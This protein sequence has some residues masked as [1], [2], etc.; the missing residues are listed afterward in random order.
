MSGYIFC[1]DGITDI[2]SEGAEEKSFEYFSL[3]N[4]DLRP[5]KDLCDFNKTV[6]DLEEFISNLPTSKYIS[7][8][9]NLT[10]YYETNYAIDFGMSSEKIGFSDYVTKLLIDEL[11]MSEKDSETISKISIRRLVKT[12]VFF[13]IA[14]S[15][16]S[17]QTLIIKTKDKQAGIALAKKLTILCPFFKENGLHIC[18]SIDPISSLKYAIVV[19]Q[20]IIGNYLDAINL[21]DIDIGIYSG[22]G[23]PPS[24]Y[25][26]KILGTCTDISESAFILNVFLRLKHSSAYFVGKLAVVSA[27]GN[28]NSPDSLLSILKEFGFSHSDIPI[29]KY[30]VYAYFNKDS[31]FKPILANNKSSLGHIL[32]P[33]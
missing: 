5:A 24:S 20:D 27:E 19:C 21:I 17:G 28:D 23:C 30:W 16:L 12:K 33:F 29:L 22:D 13:Y 6:D 14:F 32:A 11:K 9:Q 2:S 26:W 3:I 25:V 8:L 4:N 18:D 10:D 1:R 15:L 31:S 7:N